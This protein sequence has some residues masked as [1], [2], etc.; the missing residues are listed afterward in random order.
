MTHHNVTEDPTNTM[1]VTLPDD[2]NV[3]VLIDIEMTVPV[4][5]KMT[6]LVDREMTALSST[7]PFVHT[8]E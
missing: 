2:T 3:T 7:K 8:D 6:A 5:T 1:M 4:D